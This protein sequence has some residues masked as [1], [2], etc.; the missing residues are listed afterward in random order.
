MWQSDL[1]QN[2][3]V[4]EKHVGK[5]INHNENLFWVE[6]SYQIFLNLFTQNKMHIQLSFFKLT[7]CLFLFLCS[8]QKLLLCTSF[9]GFT[10][11]QLFINF[12][13]SPFS[14]VKCEPPNIQ[15]GK[16]ESGFSR[17]YYYKATIVFSCDE[18]Y[19][20]KDTNIVTCGAESTW[21]PGKP[22]CFKGTKGVFSSFYVSLTFHFFD[23]N[24]SDME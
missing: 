23:I 12:G 11:K 10:L 22:E 14:V 15:N 5:P 20:Y 8:H 1:L 17:K 24:I 2:L 9:S 19:Y 18:G 21:E 7:S 13:I 6:K 3:S 4:K 16:L